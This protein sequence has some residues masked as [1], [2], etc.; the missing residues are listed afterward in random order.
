MEKEKFDWREFVRFAAITL[1]IVIPVRIL[2]AS[3]FVVSVSSMYPTFSNGNYLIIDK[4]S[5]RLTEPKRDDVVVFR[6]PNDTTKFFIKRIIGLPFETI[7]IK[8]SVV[9]ITS[10]NK[11]EGFKLVEPYVKN[12]GNDNTH[13][14][15]KADEYF[16]M[17]DN[18]TASSDSRYWGAVSRKLLEGKA[19]LRLLPISKIDI[20]P[21]YY[22]Y[23]E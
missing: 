1:V 6:Y 22:E 7:D 15:L 11:K 18:R 9:T 19:F 14:E 8:G 17:G 20:W 13:Y 5:Y 2:V 10:E 4:I 23:K 21:G 12:T 3:P 16:V